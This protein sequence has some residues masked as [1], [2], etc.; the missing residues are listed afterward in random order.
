MPGNWWE[1]L[2]GALSAG[3]EA[4]SS[5]VPMGPLIVDGF[6]GTV[7]ISFLVAFASVDYLQDPCKLLFCSFLA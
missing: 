5:P 3:L 1:M 7:Y 2:P 4:V 6:R